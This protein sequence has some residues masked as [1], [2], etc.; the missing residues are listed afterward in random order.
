MVLPYNQNDRNHILL[1]FQ[2][3]NPDLFYA[4][5]WSYGTLGLLVATE[6]QIVPAKKYVKVDYRPAHSMSEAV[7]LFSEET[8]K[9]TGND[10][11]EALMYSKETA[12]VMTA[13]MTDDVEEHKV[14]LNLSGLIDRTSTFIMVQPSCFTVI[15]IHVTKARLEGK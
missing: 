9:E 12:V 14:G 6:V 11:V 2:D 15:Q 1:L 7:K 5:P 4:V 8:L 3:E 13:N 10:F